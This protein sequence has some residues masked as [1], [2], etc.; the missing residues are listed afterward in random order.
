MARIDNQFI[1]KII[2]SQDIEWMSLGIGADMLTTD[3]RPILVF[4]QNQLLRDGT[5]PDKS[6]VVQFFPGFRFRK[7]P[8]KLSF[9][10]EEIRKRNVISRVQDLTETLA[11][12]LAEEEP[13][14]DELART[15]EDAGIKVNFQ[16]NKIQESFYGRDPMARLEALRK[17]QSGATADYSLGF[18]VLDEDLIGAE[19]GN[20]F[21]I[22]GTPGSG[23]TW[24][25][26]KLLYNLW[27]DDLNILLFSFELS[28]KLINRRID[29]IV[30][31]VRYSKF[32]RGLISEMEKR[33]FW[34]RLQRNAK[35][36]NWMQ[37]L[38]TEN[39]DPLSK[40]GPA[41][42]EYVYSKI[43]QYKPHIVAIDGFYL[44][45]GKGDAEW[46]KM[47]YLSRGMHGIT[48]ATG[49]AGWATSQLT[50]TSDDKTPR[51]RDLSFSWTFAQD[52]DGVVLL[53][54]PEDMRA[55]HETSVTIGKFREAED[56][57]KYILRF[58]PGEEI[59]IERLSTPVE[60]PLID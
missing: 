49:V 50:K 56:N 15:V 4:I 39:C 2:K 27:Q 16:I 11:N 21:L 54:R 18:S 55:A 29:S 35:R 6:T 48:Q 38:T 23:K 28:E 58:D 5:I 36:K 10:A 46:E 52:T 9:Y 45:N 8:E 12:K 47:A 42:L 44:M 59:E 7:S 43:M 14:A 24:M 34:H 57:M 40:T 26:L 32:R 3:V 17:I 60:N 22:A 13:D 25:L 33:R 31:G 19:K 37:V 20:F 1:S 41:R 51:L 53:S 30:A